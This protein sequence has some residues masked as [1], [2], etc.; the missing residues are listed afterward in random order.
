M[1]FFV[2]RHAINSRRWGAWRWVGR[3]LC[4]ALASSALAA[5][6]DWNAELEAIRK[7]HDVPAVAAAAMIKTDLRGLGAVGVRKFGSPTK[8]TADDQWHIGSCTKSMTASLAAMLVE[9]GQI[10]W[11]TTV[12]EVFK[13]QREAMDEAWPAVTLEQ[14]LTHRAG[15]PAEPPENLW[16]NAWAQHGTPTEQRAEFVKGLLLRKPEAPPGTAFIYSNQGYSIAGA[17]LERVTGEPWEKLME[18][19]VF[20]ANLM[21][22]AG[23]GAPGSASRIDQP[24]GHGRDGEKLKPVP[25][26]PKADNPPAIGPGGTVHCSIKA[27]ARYAAWHARGEAL[28][29]ATLKKESFVKLHTPPAGGDYA[30]GWAVAPRPW[31]GGNALTHAGTNT[32]N[33]AVMWIAPGREAAFVAAT[34]C[35]GAAAEKACDEAV[36]AMIERYLK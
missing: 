14:L 31:A 12:G 7:K 24:W 13:E 16:R 32:V 30:F 20:P 4:G 8:V 5:P 1:R 27:L 23:F 18:Q 25:P 9:R 29:S 34:N 19:M 28:G 17:M 11:G 2:K 33:Y 21:S 35:G 6:D 10:Q 3:V 22:G 26:G 36:A 15:A